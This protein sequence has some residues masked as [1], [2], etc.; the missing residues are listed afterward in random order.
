MRARTSLIEAAVADKNIGNRS[1]G[2]D[3]PSTGA[4][5]GIQELHDC[6]VTD[7]C[8]YVPPSTDT[9]SYGDSFN[10]IG[11]GVY[12]LLWEETTLQ[13]WHFPRGSVPPDVDSQS[14]DPSG[15]GTPQAL[16]G[17]SSCDIEEHFADMTIVLDLVSHGAVNSQECPFPLPLSL[18]ECG[19]QWRA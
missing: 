12:A 16:F 2:C 13:V 3:L 15:W 14:P 19:R 4:W 11:G 18:D 7:G 17:T 10:A 6:S 8:N 1:T 9:S 5:T